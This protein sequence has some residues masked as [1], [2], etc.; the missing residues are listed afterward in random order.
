MAHFYLIDYSLDFVPG[1]WVCPVLE[2]EVCDVH[3]SLLGGQV[4]GS[5]SCLGLCVRL[6]PVLEEGG[7]DL[8]LVLLGRDVKRCV[9]VLSCSVRRSVLQSAET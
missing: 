5:E 4:E 8:Q 7:R 9:P 1:I 3:M 6:C 2:Q